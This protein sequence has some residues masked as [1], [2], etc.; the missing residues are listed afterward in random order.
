MEGYKESLDSLLS[1]PERVE[2]DQLMYSVF[3]RSEDGKRLL[4]IFKERFL[5]A[6]APGRMGSGYEQSCIYHEGYRE[7]FR[8]IIMMVGSY[9]QRKD[10]EAKEASMKTQER[11]KNEFI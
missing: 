8:Y 10:F 3:E 5:T 1:S 9:K 7:A 6:P 4:A 2:L 11:S